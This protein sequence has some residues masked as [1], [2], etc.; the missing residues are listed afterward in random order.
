[1]IYF[2]HLKLFAT[3][4]LIK[5][6]QLYKNWYPVYKSTVFILHRKKY[7]IK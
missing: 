5:C 2:D 3:V 1:M 4:T 7:F 6:E